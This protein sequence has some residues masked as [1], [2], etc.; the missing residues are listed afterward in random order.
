MKDFAFRGEGEEKGYFYTIL[1]RTASKFRDDVV[2]GLLK[3][4]TF[5]EELDENGK[6]IRCDGYPA[7]VGQQ[8]SL[9]GLEIKEFEPTKVVPSRMKERAVEEG[10]DEEKRVLDY[11]A[12]VED[13]EAEDFVAPPSKFR[14]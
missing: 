3:Q 12:G 6:V 4:Y 2:G 11:G 1:A 7:R 10:V 8:V 14:K 9:E 13:D 5:L